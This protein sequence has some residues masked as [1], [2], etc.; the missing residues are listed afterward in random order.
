MMIIYA[1]RYLFIWSIY[2]SILGQEWDFIVHIVISHYY[3][4]VL[5]TTVT[6]GIHVIHSLF[7]LGLLY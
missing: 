3:S 1:A 6:Y 5:G 4:L 7:I 2:N